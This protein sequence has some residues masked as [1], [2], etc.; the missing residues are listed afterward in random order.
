MALWKVSVEGE[1]RLARGSVGR[2]PEE[3]LAGT[4]TLDELLA[5][6]DGA[7]SAAMQG[8]VEGLVPETAQ[9]LAPIGSQEVWAAGVTYDR[10]R[11]GRVLESGTPDFYDEIYVSERPELFL[12]A[13]P[14][15]VRGPGAPVGIRADST[16]DVPEPELGVVSDKRGK[17]V[18]YMNGNDMSSR[19]IE[20]DNPLYLPQA[21]IYSGSCAVGPC[22]VTTD[23]VSD[24]LLLEITLR[25]VRGGVEEICET[26]SVSNLRRDPGDLVRWL[27]RGLDFPVGV[28][29]LTGTGIVPASD[30]TLHVGDE[31]R[32]ET[33]GLGELRNKVVTTGLRTGKRA[34]QEGQS[35]VKRVWEQGRQW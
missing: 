21:K 26:V 20:G 23:E 28:V 5:G 13:P 7:L 25:V 33:T 34:L 30:F 14:G 1:L 6:E 15:R 3:F 12:K 27:Y 17:I 19:S 4:A 31:I 29:I 8:P 35:E 11:K 24:P 32:I 22:L 16:W 18:G 9:I 2:G 10:S